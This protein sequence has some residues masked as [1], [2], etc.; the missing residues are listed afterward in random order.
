MNLQG[1][2]CGFAS[3]FWSEFERAGFNV[4]THQQ[5]ARFMEPP[6]IQTDER[7][8]LVD[9]H[10]LLTNALK[11]DP[12]ILPMKEKKLLRCITP[13][14]TKTLRFQTTLTRASRAWVADW[15]AIQAT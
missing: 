6:A 2:Q 8:V 7:D 10:Q 1:D 9:I 11:V 14:W 3:K 12:T 15:K 4:V 5:A 13:M